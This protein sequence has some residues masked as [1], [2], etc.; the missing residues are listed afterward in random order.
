MLGVHAFVA[1]VLLGSLKR[2]LFE[3]FGRRSK[4]QVG[5]I[6]ILERSVKAN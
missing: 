4:A 5:R 6:L 1:P 3:R 2:I